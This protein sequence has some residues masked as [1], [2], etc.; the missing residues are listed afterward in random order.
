MTVQASVQQNHIGL[1]INQDDPNE[2]QSHANFLI[3]EITNETRAPSDKSKLNE[4]NAF[5]IKSNEQFVKE[6]KKELCTF[7]VC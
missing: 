7:F 1:Q 6:R 2:K 5:H 3:E 4:Q